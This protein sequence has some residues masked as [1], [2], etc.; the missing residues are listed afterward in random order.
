MGIVYAVFNHTKKEYVHPEGLPVDRSDPVSYPYSAFITNL[1]VN[2]WRHDHV[3][4]FDDS[5]DIQ[6]D[7]ELSKRYKDRSKELWNEFVTLYG[8]LLPDI[9]PL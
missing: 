5:G 2:S 4:M 9:A 6:C 8:G 7:W 3:V 1:L